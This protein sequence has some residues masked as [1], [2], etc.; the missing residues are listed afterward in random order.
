MI[1]RRQPLANYD[2]IMTGGAGLSFQDDPNPMTWRLHL[3]SPVTKVYQTL[4][5]DAGRASFWEESASEKDRTIYFMFP[6]DLI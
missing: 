3:K 2:F 6:N 5:T 1:G 4:T